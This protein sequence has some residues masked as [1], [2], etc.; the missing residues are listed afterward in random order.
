MS[1]EKL[2]P[3]HRGFIAMSGLY[4]VHARL[5]CPSIR[6]FS[7]KKHFAIHA[8]AFAILLS[9]LCLTA[10][11]P[12]QK[13]AAQQP[14]AKSVNRVS[15]YAPAERITN[16]DTLKKQLKQYHECTCTCGCYAKDQDH[17]ADRA[18]AILRLRAAH[19]RP[20]EKLAL[21][22]DIDE[23][24]LS[25]YE[26]M[27]KADF[28]YDSA[29]FHAWINSAKAPAIPGTLR[30]YREAQALGVSVF[31]ITGRAESERDATERNL[32]EQGYQ[33]WQKLYLRSP[34]QSSAPMQV[35]K[36]G[37]RA[38]VVAEGYRIILNVGDQWSDDKGEPQAEFFVKYPDPYY[39]IL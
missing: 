37:A 4:R 6:R 17:Q 31:F 20:D 35:F 12:A 39:F 13:P 33:N 29:V 22:L 36:S 27:V 7:V 8:A 14:A 38:A 18:I 5:L 16:F 10:Q 11:Q 19:R 2:C 32:R 28:A 24:A 3:V 1:L 21:V 25:N 23:T 30:L 26:E 34:A 15:V 9:P